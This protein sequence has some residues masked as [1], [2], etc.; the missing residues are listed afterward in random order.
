MKRER[1]AGHH[2]HHVAERRDLSDESAI[3]VA[4]VDVQLSAARRRIALRHV[5][6]EDLDRRRALHEHRSK[7]SNE[8]RQDVASLERVR[9][10]DRIRF[11]P[12][13]PKQ[14]ADDFRLPIQRDEPLLERARETHPVVEVEQAGTAGSGH[15]GK[16]SADRG[17]VT[18]SNAHRSQPPSPI[19]A[20]R[21]PLP[22]FPSAAIS[23]SALSSV[24]RIFG[25][26]QADEEFLDVA[27]QTAL[28]H[29]VGFDLDERVVPA[30]RLRRELERA[31]RAGVR[32]RARRR[33][34]LRQTDVRKE[35]VGRREH[36]GGR[37]VTTIEMSH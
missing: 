15:A 7:I 29:L 10:A 19:P 13:R 24:R 36:V 35:R 23:S 33:R 20:S 27:I 32:A 28:T 22:R 2:R 31:E 34:V 17:R 1:H 21:V 9:A 3:G 4:E 11:L 30:L 14:P 37:D 6:L 26:V 25:A 8:R 12:E 18:P 16:R 5:L